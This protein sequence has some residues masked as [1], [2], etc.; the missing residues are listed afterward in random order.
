MTG[1]VIARARGEYVAKSGH[2]SSFTKGV[3]NARIFSTR[4]LAVAECCSNE[5]VLSV[6]DIFDG[7]R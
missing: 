7:A 1:Y 5:R 6:D 3:E 4:E 2:R